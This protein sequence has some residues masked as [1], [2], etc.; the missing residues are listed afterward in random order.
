MVILGRTQRCSGPTPDEPAQPG[1]A[2]QR[3]DAAEPAAARVLRRVATAYGR[4]SRHRRAVLFRARIGVA[5][6]A[7]VLDLGSEDG[8][9]IAELGLDADV[10]IADIDA[11]AVRAGAARYGFTPVV[12]PESGRL[13]FPDRYFD[14]VF[15]SSVIE[16]VTVPKAEIG[17]R[18]GTRE[19][20]RAA[21][22]RQR[23]FAAEIRRVGRCYFVQTPNRYFP[24]ESHTWLPGVVVFLPRPAQVRLIDF[25]NGWWPKRTSAD[26]YLLT[27][28]LL[29]ELFPDATVVRERSLGL[30]KSLIAIRAD[31]HQG[32]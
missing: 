23:Q 4:R 16:H 17:A 21:L 9:H 1:D 24:I 11:A 6:G 10:H 13:P 30:T 12:I 7:R 14:V 29:Q 32:Y 5:A 20:A 3:D 15:C 19:F 28:G 27:A 25:M 31:E 2:V 8:R 26:F 18:T 22:A